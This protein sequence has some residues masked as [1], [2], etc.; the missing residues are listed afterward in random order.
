[1]TPLPPPP[2]SLLLP[3]RILTLDDPA[4]QAHIGK[5]G[6]RFATVLTYLSNPEEV[7]NLF[8]CEISHR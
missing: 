3:L 8:L 4:G 6:N 5:A 7:K 2:L 1:M